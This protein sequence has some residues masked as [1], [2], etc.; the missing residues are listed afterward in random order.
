MGQEGTQAVSDQPVGRRL[1][2]QSHKG[3]K[4][5]ATHCVVVDVNWLLLLTSRYSV[6]HRSSSVAAAAAAAIDAPWVG[7]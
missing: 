3:D 6:S 5:V 2:L 1:R 4:S 7:C